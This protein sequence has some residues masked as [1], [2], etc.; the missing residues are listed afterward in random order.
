[1]ST[2]AARGRCLCGNIRFRTVGEPDVSTQMR[3]N[4]II[5][6]KYTEIPSN[7]FPLTSDSS[8]Y[9]SASQALEFAIIDEVR[10]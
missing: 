5:I 7:W 9:M 3:D 8:Y 4:R 10:S 6:V 1:M 2:D